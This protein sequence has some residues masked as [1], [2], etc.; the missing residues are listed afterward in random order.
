M[1]WGQ[2]ASSR[3]GKPNPLNLE[4]TPTV[5]DALFDLPDAENYA[6]LISRDW[7]STKRYG[8]PS[9]YAK[10]LRCLSNDAWSFGKVRNWTPEMLTSSA[11]TDHTEISRRRF[12]STAYGKVEPISRL[13]K[14]DPS[15]ISNTLRAGTDS[16]RGAFTSP[17]PIHPKHNRCIT[18]R[19]MARLH[20]FPDWFRFHQTKWHGARQIGNAVPPPLARAVAKEVITALGYEPK[21]SSETLELGEKKLLTMDVSEASRYWNI[22]NPI[23]QRDRKSGDRKRSQA[24]IERQLKEMVAAE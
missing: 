24:E 18:V 5:A 7:V 13:F 20:G 23:K 16:S 9:N 8:T 19:E 11:R 21:C 10:Q 17:R 12:K 15:G 4:L 6:S 22:K 3:P 14:L 1:P 2:L